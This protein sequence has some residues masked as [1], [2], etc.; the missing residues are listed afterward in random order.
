MAGAC[1]YDHAAARR[2]VITDWILR[3]VDCD[4]G[5]PARDRQ[6]IRVLDLYPAVGAPRQIWRATRFDKIPSQQENSR[7]W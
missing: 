5:G 7:A 4:L 6:R 3:Y 1:P 2:K